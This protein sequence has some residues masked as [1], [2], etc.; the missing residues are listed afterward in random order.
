[1]YGTRLLV[2]TECSVYDEQ[3]VCNGVGLLF[4]LSVG[5]VIGFRVSGAQMV[6]E[7]GREKY[8]HSEYS[9]CRA[10]VGYA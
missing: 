1:M 5:D 4:V 8:G 2:A 10:Y 9:R 3:F 6:R 7:G